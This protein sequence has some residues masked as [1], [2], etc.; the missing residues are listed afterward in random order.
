MYVPSKEGCIK[1]ISWDIIFISKFFFP[2]YRKT[3][4][5][6]ICFFNYQSPHF[7]LFHNN[8]NFNSFTLISIQLFNRTAP[9][10]CSNLVLWFNRWMPLLLCILEICSLTCAWYFSVLGSE[11]Q[12]WYIKKKYIMILGPNVSWNSTHRIPI[13]FK[14]KT[15]S[16][17]KCMEELWSQGLYWE[18]TFPSNSLNI[19][20]SSFFVDKLI[21]IFQ[22]WI[23]TCIF[24]ILGGKYM[25]R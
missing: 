22:T 23:H 11:K 9:F 5:N 3:Y 14:K 24:N 25:Y 4:L 15:S 19:Y 21:Q 18:K 7:C 12:I 1:I 13:I 8:N 20:L 16:N 10:S 2:H 6:S 17:L